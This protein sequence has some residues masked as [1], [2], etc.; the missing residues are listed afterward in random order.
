[1]HGIIFA[2]LH[3]YTRDRLGPATTADIFAGRSYAMSETHPD[4]DLVTLLERTARKRD[5]PIDELLRDFGAFTA[6]HTFARLYPAFFEIAGDTRTF[7]LGVE[8]R[9]HE[10]VRAT[11]PNAQ[12]PALLVRRDGDNGLEIHYSSPRR[13]CRLLEGLVIGTGRHYNQQTAIIETACMNNG[14]PACRFTVQLTS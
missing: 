9:I 8:N 13:L 2:S 11:I 4:A 6:E 5:L 7:L 10:L 12:P 14:H 3:D 1:M